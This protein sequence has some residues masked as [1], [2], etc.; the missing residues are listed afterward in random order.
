[1]PRQKTFLT[2]ENMLDKKPFLIVN[3]IIIINSGN[4]E[5]IHH[6]HCFVLSSKQDKEI[7][8]IS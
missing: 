2:R 5:L 7:L 6:I 3:K 1:M 4:Q 8:L